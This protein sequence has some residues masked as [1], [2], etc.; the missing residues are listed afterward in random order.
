MDGFSV[1]TR[2]TAADWKALSVASSRRTQGRGWRGAAV[3]VGLPA[4]IWALWVGLLHFVHSPVEASSLGIGVVV[5]YGAV[6]LLFRIVRSWHKPAA[7][8]NFLGEWHYDFSPLGI[9]IRR[10]HS[11]SMWSWGAVREIALSGEHLFIWVDSITAFLVP[12][13]DLPGGLSGEQAQVI[14]REM[15]AQVGGLQEGPQLGMVV[16]A[17]GL[18]GTASAPQRPGT[19]SRSLVAL[20]RWLTW[21]RFEARA[22]AAPDAAIVLVSLICLALAI[23]LDYSSV[24]PKAQFNWYDAPVLAVNALGLMAIGWVVWRAADPQP[25]WRAVLFILATL[26]LLAVPLQ[27][28]IQH[29]E[30]DLVQRAVS[31]ILVIVL[32]IYLARALRVIT[33][34][35]QYRAVA[36]SMLVLWVGNGL[37]SSYLDLGPL[38]YMPVRDPESYAQRHREI[39]RLLM[40]QP[41]RIDAAV[42]SMAPRSGDT[43]LFMVGFAGVGRQKVFA[44]EIGLAAKV[45]GDRYGTAQRTL[46]LVNDQRDLESHPLA[47]VTGLKL[48]LADIGKRMDRERDA[49]ILFISSHGSQEP[50]ISVSNGILPLND[51]TGK[52]LKEALE[53]AQIRWRVIIISACHSGAFIPYLNDDHTIVITAAAPDRTSFGCSNDRDLTYFGEAFI[54]DALPGS[55]T[56]RAAFEQAR[57]S[58]AAREKAEGQTPSM[59]TASFGAAM[60]EKLQTLEKPLRKDT[61]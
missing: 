55:S 24:G 16:A 39:E 10:K 19:V 32:A 31:W 41:A 60:E 42:A 15:Q 1:N 4:L 35:R 36:I 50:A 12:V 48:A 49:L 58:I 11:D 37:V 5:G 20:V 52:D 44:G 8:G 34:Y 21:R 9:R 18:P 23:G 29:L 54:R 30:S 47:S 56:L 6:Y 27:W 38:W 61:R 25:A 14:L 43:S 45:I 51:L 3:V 22:L 53:E 7:D 13:R 40:T 17:G 59:P 26:T 33:G 46:L 57:T 28:G 2:L